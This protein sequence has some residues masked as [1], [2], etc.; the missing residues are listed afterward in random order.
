MGGELFDAIVKRWDFEEITDILWH[1]MWISMTSYR[2][3]YSERDAAI[4]V[5]QITEAIGY[6]H[7][8]GIVHRDLKVS[9]LGFVL[10]RH[11]DVISRRICWLEGAKLLIS[12][13]QIS[14]WVK[15]S[16]TRPSWRQVRIFPE[17][18]PSFLIF[19]NFLEFSDLV[20][21]V[22]EFSFEWN[23]T[24]CGTPGYVAPEVLQGDGYNQA[25]DL[26]SIGVITYILWVDNLQRCS[27]MGGLMKLG[28][29]ASRLFMQIQIRN[30]SR[31][32]WMLGI[33]SQTP[34]GPRYNFFIFQADFSCF[35]CKNY[36]IN[37]FVNTVDV[38]LFCKIFDC[39]RF[40]TLQ[41]IWFVT[42]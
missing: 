7:N 9:Y 42:F 31:K 22:S 6:L 27:E 29:V 35:L 13:L 40:P 30:F 17:I 2:G 20:C 19:E 10:W 1:L 8:K 18:S 21:D 34:T 11:D 16:K 5:K 41:K 15:S 25:V 23:C 12:K 36:W 37:K 32:F 28:C 4:V 39:C 24:A 14:D 26:W 3:K 38:N 33:H